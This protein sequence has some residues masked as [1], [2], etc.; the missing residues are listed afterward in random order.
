MAIEPDTRDISRK[1]RLRDLGV[2]F[3]V[4]E[5]GSM[6]KAS[7]D[8]GVTQ[9]AVSQII[10]GLEADLGVRLFD[11]SR[12]GVELTIYGEALIRRG[13]AA[14]DELRS[15]FQ[16]IDFLKNEG[17]GQIR[18]GCPETLAASVLPVAID[19][20]TSRWPGVALEV[21]TFPGASSAAKLL[22]RSIDLVLARDGPSLAALA[23]SEDFRITRLFEDQLRVVVGAD[24]RWANLPALDLADLSDAPWIVL[25]YGWGEDVIPAA[26]ASRGLPAPQIALKTFSIHLRLH[27]LMTG[28]FVSALP[29]SVLRLHG[30]RFG[31][32]EL[33]IDLPRMPYGVAIVTLKNR[34]L[35]RVVEEFIRATVAQFQPLNEGQASILDEAP[36]SPRTQ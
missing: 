15:G 17:A 2:V 11:R 22:D 21:E 29:A 33:P 34:T 25:P 28:R 36:A 7:I 9:S 1:L 30:E 10:A 27:L 18:I 3:A 26:F 6:A 32:K 12:R 8:L 35:I 14:F 5:S 16:E 19:H 31:L 23:A 20:F 4:A 24:S 13:R